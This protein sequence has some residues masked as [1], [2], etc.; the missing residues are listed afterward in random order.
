MNIRIFLEKQPQF[1]I[2]ALGIFL[3]ALIGSA[4]YLTGPGL[5]LSI[6]FVIVIIL[7]TWF[8]GQRAGILASIL[9]AFTGLL[10]DLATRAYASPVIPFWNAAARLGVFLI[11]SLT[12]SSLLVARARQEEMVHFL[13]HDLRSPLANILTGLTLL[14][15]SDEDNLNEQQKHLVRIGLSSGNQLMTLVNSIL[16]VAKFES[17]KMTPLVQPTPVTNLFEACMQQVSAMA[18][19]K[20]M[21]VTG[22]ALEGAKNVLCDA[23]LTQ[24][25]LINLVSNALKHSPPE[26]TILMEARPYTEDRIAIRVVDSGTGIPPEWLRRVF[27]RFAQ[28]PLSYAETRSGTGLGLRFC[29]LAVEAQNGRIWLDSEVGAGTIVTFTLPR[30]EAE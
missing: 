1:L 3:I 12:L 4:D 24:R 22:H 23:E 17:S 28:A 26:T 18:L 19:D 14:I 20:Q 6:L 8:I 30:V 16:D 2:V 29:R 25:V 15:D 13:V 27:G 10:V 5:I 11:V 9:S 21:R 7:L